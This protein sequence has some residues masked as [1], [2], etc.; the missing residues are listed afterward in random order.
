MEF[1]RAQKHAAIKR[2]IAMR[3]RVYPRW[4]GSGKMKDDEA[5]REIAIMEAIA[6]DYEEPKLI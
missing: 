5:E 2:E 4:T 1:T 6:A 3:K